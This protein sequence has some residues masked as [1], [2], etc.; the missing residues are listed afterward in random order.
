MWFFGPKKAFDTVDHALLL[1]KLRNYGIRGDEHSW[2]T[3]Y[4]TDR[5]QSV[6][7]E[8]VTSDSMDI[9]Y[10]VPQGSILGPLLF[11][12][13]INDLPS[14]TKTCK[15]I[16]YADDTAIIYSEK[17]K[18][19]IEKHLNDDM[20]IVK[21]WLDENKLTL[22][23][24]K[25]KSMLIGNKK[26]L[27]EAEHLAVRLDMDSIEQVGEFKYLGVW[28]DSSLKFTC[29]ISKMS[30]KISSAIGVISRVSRYLPVVQRKMLYNAMVLPYFN[31]TAP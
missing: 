17:Q 8:N 31:Y 19:Q 4:L 7:L 16:L 14:V 20:A 9:S 15:A 30:S 29:H 5:T 28:L 24:K 1:T 25:T 10:G 23:V 26:L 18:E 11:T 12:L 21:T 22:N 13:Y 3:S 2:F 27:N 6:S